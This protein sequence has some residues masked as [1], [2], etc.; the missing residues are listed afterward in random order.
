MENETLRNSGVGKLP[1]WLLP[2]Y[3][4]A[5]R[6]LPWRE[7]IVP[8]HTWLSEIMLQQT[9]VEAVIPYYH[10]F[11]KELPDIP[12]LAAAG[13][14]QIH[15]LWEGLGYYSRVRN[16][17]KAAVILCRDYGGQLP[18]DEQSLKKLPGIG[19]YTAGA[20]ASI[21]FGQMA[22]AVDGNV[23]RVLSRFLAVQ[24][25]ISAPAVRRW[26]QDGARAI[27]PPGR[28]GDFNQSLMELGATVCLPNGAPLCGKC[29]LAERCRA[30]E[31]GTPSLFPVK[32]PK[33]PRKIIPRTVL[34]FCWEDRVFLNKRPEKGLL[35]RLWEPFSL[36]GHVEEQALSAV[37]QQKGIRPRSLRSLGEAKHIFTHLEWEMQGYWALLEKP[38]PLLETGEWITWE[39]LK[40]THAVPGAFRP[41]VEKLKK[42]EGSHAIRPLV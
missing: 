20:I 32:A 37:L 1:E 29:P 22:P 38:L 42:E 8:Y 26:F 4:K 11:L 16:M 21:A 9:R 7:E 24:E 3:D 13:E 31:Q 41:F 36:E 14:G 33:K 34:F 25:D 23:L 19:D 30:K 28:P 18:P 40:E 2:W 35:A 15:K 39:Q 5:R 12:S 27:L 10:R 17:Q 6:R